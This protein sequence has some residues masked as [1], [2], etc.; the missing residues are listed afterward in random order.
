MTLADLL[1][2]AA[3]NASATFNPMEFMMALRES[4]VRLD[5]ES[6]RSLAARCRSMADKLDMLAMV[7]A[8]SDGAPK[9]KE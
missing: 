9:E 6:L 7:V 2:R 5:A 1:K 3:A 4:G 8:A